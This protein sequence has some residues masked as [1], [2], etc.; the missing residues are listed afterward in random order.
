MSYLSSIIFGF[1]LVV[2]IS[3]FIR[4]CKKI[5]RNIKIGNNIDRLDNNNLRLFKM[6]RLAFGQSKMLD[7]P[8]V[9]LLHLI[10]Y[11]AFILINVE[12]LPHSQSVCANKL[13]LLLFSCTQ[14]QLRHLLG[15]YYGDFMESAHGA[16]APAQY[17]QICSQ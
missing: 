8:V 3:F 5:I 13:C 16:K 11:I 6:L 12:F 7:K 17:L 4:N 2:S 9:G 1:I 15:V 14:L 10:V